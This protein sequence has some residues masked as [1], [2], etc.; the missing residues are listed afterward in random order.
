V[1]AAARECFATKGVARTRM[2]D[3]AEAAG[4]ARQNVYRYVSGR[5][6]LVELAIV[7]R[8][9]EFAETLVGQLDPHGGDLETSFVDHVIRSAM[10]GRQDAE[11]VYLT[12]ALPRVTL[13]LLVGGPDAHETVRRAFEPLIRRAHAEGALRTDVSEDEM[14]YWLQ[15]ILTLITPRVDLDEAALRRMVE[16]FTLPA[17]LKSEPGP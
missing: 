2:D 14:I 10:L 3:V 4:M 11:F 9:R 1:V 8:L 6:E 16:K 12:D 15:G 7:E 13:N 5:D 17:L